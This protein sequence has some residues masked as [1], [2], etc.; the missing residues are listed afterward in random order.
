MNRRVFA[1]TLAVLLLTFPAGHSLRASGP[2]YTVEDLG[3]T[4]DGFVPTVTGMNASGQVSGYVSRPDGLRAVRFTDGLG[5]TYPPGLQSVYSA[6]TAIN[7]SGDLT[8][9]YLPA[10]LRAFRYVDGVGVTTIP[11]LPTGSY[12]IGYAIATARVRGFLRSSRRPSAVPPRRLA[13]STTPV[14]SSVRSRR[15][16]I[17]MRSVSTPS[18]R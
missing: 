12:G 14:R 8:G 15:R 7:A 17:S 1:A 11:V 3:T 18:A 5:W 10:G 2:V 4:S 9:Y 16:G 6:A 13:G